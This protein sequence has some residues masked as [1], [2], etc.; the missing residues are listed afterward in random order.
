MADLCSYCLRVTLQIVG[1]DE[2]EMPVVRCTNCNY[3]NVN[4][5]LT[6]QPSGLEALRAAEHLMGEPITP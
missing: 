5:D 3:P 2:N 4:V 6:D 1:C